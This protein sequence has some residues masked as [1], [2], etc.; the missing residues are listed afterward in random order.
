MASNGSFN[1][2][3][4]EVRYLTFY[5]NVQ[6]QSVD[7]NQTTIAW[8][9]KGN[10]ANPSTWYMSGNFKVII[11]GATVF[12]SESRIELLPGTT[13][14]S[15]TFTLNHLNDG[16][17]NF[18]VYI[19][20]GIYWYAVNCKASARFDLPTIARATQ[21]TVNKQTMTY[22]EQITISLPRASGGF[23]HTIQ[24][25]INGTLNFINVV[26][27]IG[28]AYNW[29]LPKDWAKY[30]PSSNHRIRIKAITYSG[31]VYI[32]EK[33]ISNPISVTPTQDMKPVVTIALSDETK[34]NATYGGFVKGQSKIRAKVTEQLYAG[35]SV[36]S[37]SLTLNGIKYQTAEQVSDVIAIMPQTIS[38]S[39]TDA[40]GLTGTA[41][42]T[43]TIFDWYKPK[44]LVFKVNRC[45]KTGKIDEVGNFLRI[46]YSIDVALINNKN[47]KSLV[48]GIKKQTDTNWVNTNIPLS[49][50]KVTSFV[51][52]AA[53]GDFSW[54]VS[55]TLEDSFAS[56]VVSNKIGTAFVLM[57]FHKS[58]KG[59]SIG[60]VSEKEAIVEIAPLWNLMYKEKIIGDFIE[61]QGVSGIW[62]WRKW[63]S[64]VAEC[65]SYV[66]LETKA[67][68]NYR[69][70]AVTLPFPFLNVNYN[71]QAS[72]ARNGV[73][74]NYYWIGAENGDF[75]RTINSFQINA[76]LNYSCAYSVAFDLHVIGKWK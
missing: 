24:I 12:S 58:G 65:W 29:T 36:L 67:E 54:D 38:A 48:Y 64:G 40:R 39:V 6:S 61:Q 1:T 68:S 28:T 26:T 60:K 11:E 5:W 62:T 35:T 20:A 31:G 63:F 21:P 74:I 30:L 14:A 7:K 57:D 23:T 34:L 43:P 13:V 75:A 51:V 16:S 69:S 27:G 41:S 8:S 66:T 32:G 71:V 2:N 17:K 37:R 45:D 59:L 25:G 4:Y 56:T 72:P 33:E 76:S 22:G 46:D 53:S 3:T 44:I 55:L 42:V 18:G 19:E 73:I 9:L 52:V 10:G 50:N 47:A 70:L 49:A 15:G